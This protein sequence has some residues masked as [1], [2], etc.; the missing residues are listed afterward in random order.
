MIKVR[1]GYEEHT[2][3]VAQFSAMNSTRNRPAQATRIEGSKLSHQH[4]VKVVSLAAFSDLGWGVWQGCVP[5]SGRS[6][7]TSRP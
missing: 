7:C 1:E 3:H 5:V 4:N 6:H 2:G